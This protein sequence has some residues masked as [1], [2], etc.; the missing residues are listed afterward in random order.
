[1]KMFLKQCIL[2]SKLLLICFTLTSCMNSVYKKVS[3]YIDDRYAVKRIERFC[4]SSLMD[5]FQLW[6]AANEANLVTDY[7][8]THQNDKKIN[9]IG[10]KYLKNLN[11]DENNLENFDKYT[12]QLNK[13]HPKYFKDCIKFSSVGCKQ[14]SREVQINCHET[15]VRKYYLKYLK[16]TV[17]SP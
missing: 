3:N 5:L 13:L 6:N 16:E 1:M 15:H 8:T 11:T 7:F 14:E 4:S 10:Q 2:I 9:L 12:E 17:S